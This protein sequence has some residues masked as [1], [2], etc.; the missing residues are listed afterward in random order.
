M[1]FDQKVRPH[2]FDYLVVLKLLHLV[3]FQKIESCDFIK[4]VPLHPWLLRKI[5]L[6]PDSKR[7][8]TGSSE[9]S[10]SESKF[11]F[12]L[13]AEKSTSIYNVFRACLLQSYRHF[14]FFAVICVLHRNLCIFIRYSGET[15]ICT[16][17]YGCVSVEAPDGVTTTGGN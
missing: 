2:A 9:F 7:Q 4:H 13:W 15:A 8:D 14:P 10:Q 11:L 12:V 16:N 1:T 17:L 6:K 5:N 3:L